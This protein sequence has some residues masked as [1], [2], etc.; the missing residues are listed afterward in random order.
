[1]SLLPQI[2][3]LLAILVSSIANNLVS[4]GGLAEGF[5]DLARL[6]SKVVPKALG[7]DSKVVVKVAF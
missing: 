2:V 5:G 3:I 1:M 6:D 7:I 4:L